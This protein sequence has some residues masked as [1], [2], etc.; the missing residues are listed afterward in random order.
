[1]EIWWYDRGFVCY[2]FPHFLSSCHLSHHTLSTHLIHSSKWYLITQNH[3]VF[4]IRMVTSSISIG[5]C[6]MRCVFKKK[7]PFSVK[8]RLLSI[9]YEERKKSLDAIT[10]L[11]VSVAFFLSR[12]FFSLKKNLLLGSKAVWFRSHHLW[13]VNATVCLCFFLFNL[14]SQLDV[15]LGRM[16]SRYFVG[17]KNANTVPS[18]YYRVHKIHDQCSIQW[19]W[20]ESHAEKRNWQKL[21][22]KFWSP[23]KVWWIR[24]ERMAL[25]SF[26]FFDRIQFTNICKN[27]TLL[28]SKRFLFI[29]KSIF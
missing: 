1:M 8:N 18:F 13:I 24:A 10:R 6:S 5:R 17:A 2:L 22:P 19:E 4:P 20:K 9:R 14:F 25:L 15:E 26:V 12:F 16:T 29:P 27:Y 28:L 23:H 7:R 21:I 11:D 3:K